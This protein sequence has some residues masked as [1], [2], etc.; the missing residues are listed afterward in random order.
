MRFSLSCCTLLVCFYGSPGSSDLPALLKQLATGTVSAEG[1]SRIVS[2]AVPSSWKQYCRNPEGS[3]WS[4]DIDRLAIRLARLSRANR[5]GGW[6]TPFRQLLSQLSFLD[7]STQCSKECRTSLV[8]AE[9]EALMEYAQA[10]K[11]LGWLPK[12]NSRELDLRA[13]NLVER[14]R[15][16]VLWDPCKWLDYNSRKRKELHLASAPPGGQPSRT[17]PIQPCTAYAFGLRGQ[18]GIAGLVPCG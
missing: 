17:D 15:E 12:K 3:T 16:I 2:T 7:S 18:I 13:R 9:S 1:A 5:R 10:G 11:G 4:L 14:S 6:R 8:W